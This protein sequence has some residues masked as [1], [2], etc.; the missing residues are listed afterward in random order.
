MADIITHEETI[1]RWLDAAVDDGL[2]LDLTPYL[3]TY[4][5]DY[6]RLRRSN[7]YIRKC[8][9]TAK[10]R[11]VGVDIITTLPGSLDRSHGKKRLAG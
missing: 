8:T 2:Y 11:V 6:E 9:T 1:P 3:D 5:K 7:P 10:G 4:L